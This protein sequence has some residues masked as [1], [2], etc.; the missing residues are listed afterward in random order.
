[1]AGLLRFRLGQSAAV[2]VAVSIALSSPAFAACLQDHAIYTDRDD[3]YTLTFKSTPD[4]QPVAASN[5]FTIQLN[6]SDLKLDGVVMWDKDGG[7]PN[8]IVMYNCPAGDVTGDELQQCT[9][10]KGVIYALKEGADAEL[11]PMA[12]EPS[13]QALLL[14]DFSGAMS[15][16]NFKLEKP[17][18]T[19]PWE[20]FRFKECVPEQ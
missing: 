9:V 6:D 1:M 20:V 18:E 7:R 13:A 15:G 4:D 5:Q 2:F 12:K 17:I 10:W 11:L 8:G 3:N 16:F 19:F 14:P